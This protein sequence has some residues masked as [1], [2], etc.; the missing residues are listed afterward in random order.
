MMSVICRSFRA[1]F[2]YCLKFKRS[3]P[4]TEPYTFSKS[5]PDD[6]MVPEIVDKGCNIMTD[7][8]IC[9]YLFDGQ[10][11]GQEVDWNTIVSWKPEDGIL[12]IH[13]NYTQ[14]NT[15][16]WLETNSNLDAITVAA[17]I[18]E[19]TRP[20]CIISQDSLLVFLRSVNLN[21]G[22]APEEMV[23][24]RV[25]VDQSRI[26]SVRHRPLYSIRDI[27]DSIERKRGPK[28]VS[29]F[30][31]RLTNYINDHI[32]NAIN[33]IEE[34]LDKLEEDGL[35]SSMKH[36]QQ[37]AEIRRNSIIMRRYVAPLREVH[38]KLQIEGKTWFSEGECIQLRESC[39][40]IIRYIEDLDLVRERVIVNQEELSSRVSEQINNKMLLLS[41]V[42]AIFLPLS[43]VTGLLGMNLGGIPGATSTH[44]F[45]LVSISLTVIGVSAIIFFRFKKWF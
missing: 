21:P 41:I 3:C 29:S 6:R 44:S 37:L 24:I 32:G 10:G 23:S 31:I 30:L 8:L 7:G 2:L 13:L 33:D 16:Q 11:G 45:M 28:T 38:Y 36:R 12:W 20:R 9:A 14:E 5:N 34:E 19:E 15:K 4:T 22:E 35:D 42:A 17:M 39:D 26:I 18:A 25:W 43:F 27:R 1:V 40:R